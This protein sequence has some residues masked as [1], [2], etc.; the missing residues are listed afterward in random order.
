MDSED[1]EPVSPT[2]FTIPQFGLVPSQEPTNW[3]TQRG[4]RRNFAPQQGPPSIPTIETP[5]KIRHALGATVADPEKL[6]LGHLPYELQTR[7][8]R[9]ASGPQFFFLTTQPGGLALVGPPAQKGIGLT[10]RL[11][12][13]IYTEDKTL[14]VIE[15][16][17]YWVDPENDIF[18]VQD[19]TRE[20][21]YMTWLRR[22]PTPVPVI[23]DE[24]LA[25]IDRTFMRNIAVDFDDFGFPNSEVYLERYVCPVFPHIRE[26]HVLVAKGHPEIPTRRWT[27]ETLVIEDMPKTEVLASPVTGIREMWYMIEYHLKKHL[28]SRGGW[29]NGQVPEVVP[30]WASAQEYDG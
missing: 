26:L 18:Y 23:S 15:N 19:K 4:R 17:V 7:I 29:P 24:Q 27:A 10:C 12:R 13:E 8:F 16:R 22:R 6:S 1:D 3:R 20:P 9:A 11:A 5:P 30:H 14:H 28:A 21:D 25:S 2:G